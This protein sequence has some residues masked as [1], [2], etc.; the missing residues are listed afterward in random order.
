MLSPHL[1][2]DKKVQCHDK[3]LHLVMLFLVVVLN[4]RKQYSKET[5]GENYE[6]TAL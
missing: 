3:K 2:L 1:K 6:D 4:H 5:K